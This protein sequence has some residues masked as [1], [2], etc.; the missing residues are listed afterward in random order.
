MLGTVTN[1][2]K[3]LRYGPA[4]QELQN[5]ERNRPSNTPSN[6]GD[7]FASGGGAAAVA[8][9]EGTLDEVEGSQAPIRW[10]GLVQEAEALFGAK[11]CLLEKRE[12]LGSLQSLL[13]NCGG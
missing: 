10:V 9:P 6:S 8:T 4:P 13:V 1:K 5:K 11:T 12:R 3:L 7:P 2:K